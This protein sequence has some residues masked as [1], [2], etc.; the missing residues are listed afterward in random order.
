MFEL[1]NWNTLIKSY[2]A[3]KERKK[4]YFEYFKVWIW[5]RRKK[6]KKQLYKTLISIV[7]TLFHNA[8]VKKKSPDWRV[9]EMISLVRKTKKEGFKV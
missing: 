6:T 1:I 2:K 9:K 7:N 4:S 5:V 8:E 3:K